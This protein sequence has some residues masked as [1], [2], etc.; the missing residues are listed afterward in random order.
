MADECYKTFRRA[1]CRIT[2]ICGPHTFRTPHPDADAT[3]VAWRIDNLR[4][5]LHYAP[6]IGDR[7]PAIWVA[8]YTWSGV[9]TDR[10]QQTFDRIA[11]LIGERNMQFFILPIRESPGDDMSGIV[12]H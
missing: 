9:R 4:M 8:R 11:R 10:A 3:T 7:L 6:A 2:A 1:E 5:F 12:R